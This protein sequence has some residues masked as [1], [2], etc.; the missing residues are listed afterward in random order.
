MLQQDAPRCASSACHTRAA[1]AAAAAAGAAAAATAAETRTVIA[2]V[3]PKARRAAIADQP[4]AACT[5]RSEAARTACRVQHTPNPQPHTTTPSH[6]VRRMRTAHNAKRKGTARRHSR[7]APRVSTYFLLSNMVWGLD[8]TWTPCIVLCTHNSLQHSGHVVHS[9]S[10]HK[11]RPEFRTFLR[12]THRRTGTC[13]RR[14]SHALH[15][16][17]RPYKHIQHRC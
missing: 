1:G 14:T 11:G 16:C 5:Q 12:S 10:L 17:L 3:V 6:V 4:N 9:Q 13:P 2:V 8:R 15:S 7:P